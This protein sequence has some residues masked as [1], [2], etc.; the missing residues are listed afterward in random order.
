MGSITFNCD[1]CERSLEMGE[2]FAGEKVACPY[3]GDV[4]VV[5]LSGLSDELAEAGE[6]P[7]ARSASSN[8]DDDRPK[9]RPLDRAEAAGLPPDSGPEKT[10]ML[11]RP[12]MFRARPILFGAE[13]LATLAGLGLLVWGL[14]DGQIAFTIGGAVLC[15]IGAVPLLIWWIDR[16]GASLRITNKRTIERRG[17]LSRST[18]E[19]LHDNSVNGSTWKPKNATA[20]EPILVEPPSDP[21]NNN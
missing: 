19:V 2:K 3:C 4:N 16:L 12:V 15:L 20:V 5:P 18:S 11:I 1:A 21:A 8:R 13:F 14:A 17:L 9:D 6:I 7:T 10:V